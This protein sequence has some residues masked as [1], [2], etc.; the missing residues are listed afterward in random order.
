MFSGNQN[1]RLLSVY[2]F[3]SA[4]LTVQNE[5]PS[6]PLHPTKHLPHIISSIPADLFLH[7]PGHIYKSR[8]L[9]GYFYNFCG[10][11]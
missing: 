8:F 2:P 9:F 7:L 3:Q 11:W 4:T 1:T 10:Y 6:I 5:L